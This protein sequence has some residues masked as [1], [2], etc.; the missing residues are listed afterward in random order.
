MKSIAMVLNQTLTN[1]QSKFL[2][3]T[4]FGRGLVATQKED[5]YDHRENDADVREDS[6]LLN[7]FVTYTL[8]AA[9]VGKGNLLINDGVERQFV[10]LWGIVIDGKIH[11][12]GELPNRSAGVRAHATRAAR[13]LDRYMNGPHQKGRR[14]PK[15]LPPN[16]VNEKGW[17]VRKDGMTI[18]DIEALSVPHTA[19]TTL[20]EE[21]PK[22]DA[23]SPQA[24][25]EVP[26]PIKN[27]RH[28]EAATGRD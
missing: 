16:V 9:E 24:T 14:T 18:V 23:E 17:L 19:E 6:D 22:L 11:V 1:Y 26:L 13:E 21:T 25:I 28:L 15:L 12:Y 8:P 2:G 3:K 7:R 10:A 5:A 4:Q 27:S 20:T